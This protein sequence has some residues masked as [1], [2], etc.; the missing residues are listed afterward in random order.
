MLT[1]AFLTTLK[2]MKSHIT[3]SDL[4]LQV[5]GIMVELRLEQVPHITTSH[6]VDLQGTMLQI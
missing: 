2:D 1:Y 4:L 3:L 5:R 6:N